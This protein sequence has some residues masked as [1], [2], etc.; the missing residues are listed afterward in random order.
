MTSIDNIIIRK[1][2]VFDISCKCSRWDSQEYSLILETWLKKTD[3]QTLQNNTKP[4]A[5]GEL[6][7]ILDRPVYY[8]KTWEGLNTLIFE[9]N[10]S[11]SSNLKNMRDRT[12]IYPK[13]ITSTPIPGDSG[14]LE[15]K[16]ESYISGERL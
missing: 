7:K 9:P 10:I 11:S 3:L 1:D 14:W 12:V 5:V 13:N 4:G 16:I 6:Y 2:G 15:V 8:D